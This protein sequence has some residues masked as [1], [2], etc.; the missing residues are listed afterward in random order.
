MALRDSGDAPVVLRSSDRSTG[1][2][3]GLPESPGRPAVGGFGE[4]GRPAPNFHPEAYDEQHP[5]GKR[6]SANF[7]R[8]AGV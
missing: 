7:F 2:T 5:D 3:E 4:V 1:P 8:I 6:L